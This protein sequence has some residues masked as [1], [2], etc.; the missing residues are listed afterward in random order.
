MKH[1]LL[2]SALLL[3]GASACDK[4]GQSTRAPAD[5][6]GE[7]TTGGTV[8]EPDVPQEPDPPQIADAAEHYAFGRY[9][10]VIATL[11]PVYED[12]KARSQY[13]AG[14]LAGA[15]LALA[16]AKDVFERGQEPSQ[17]ALAMAD[18][19]ADP[20]V[21]ALAKLAHGAMLLGNE[22]YEAAE[23]SFAAATESPDVRVKALAELL[24]AEALINRA[25]GSA[26]S[27]EIENPQHLESARAAY[28]SA[29]KTAEAEGHTI[30]RA[31]AE[32]GLAAIAK[33]QRKSDAVCTH[34]AAAVEHFKAAG[35]GEDMLAVAMDLARE[36]KC[37]IPDAS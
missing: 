18:K 21:V 16:H 36:Q 29:A 25:F 23:R 14:G 9:Q 3:C 7:A 1:A 17:H 37:K 8:A 27:T 32:E 11:E 10:D 30:L 20:E 22:D 2:L 4:K 6:A 26:N 31:R 19:T 13:R 24:R 5:D 33:Y 35:A 15:W 12:L 34:V 28:E